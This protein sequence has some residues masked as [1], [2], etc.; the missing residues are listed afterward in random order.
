M[1]F[2]IDDALAA[3]AAGISLT[4]TVVQTVKRYRKEG[5]DY[6][7]E[8]LLEEVRL[9]ALRRIDDAD[10]ALAQFERML[11]EKGVHTDMSLMDII[12]DVPFWNPV[13][14]FRLKKLRK[15]FNDFADS[16]YSACDDVAALARCRDRV[17]PMGEAIVESAHTKHQLHRALLD[18]KSLK[19]SIDLLRARL[20]SQ[21]EALTT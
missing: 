5:A 15:R 11:S 1:A 17:R 2:G 13:E 16:I 14:Q 4:D 10:E 12:A 21:K 7:L 19:E 3:A 20:N 18:S 9:T 8:I 6:D